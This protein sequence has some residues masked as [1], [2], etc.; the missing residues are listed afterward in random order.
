MKLCFIEFNHTAELVNYPLCTCL[1]S[2][3]MIEI[4]GLKDAILVYLMSMKEYYLNHQN[5]LSLL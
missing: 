3:L 1:S 2:L 5:Q 4:L